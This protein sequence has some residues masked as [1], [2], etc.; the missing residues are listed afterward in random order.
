M[1]RKLLSTP[2]EK[3]V[4]SEV[5]EFVKAHMDDMEKNSQ[6]REEKKNRE[7]YL[8]DIANTAVRAAELIILQHI[9]DDFKDI[10]E[11][12]IATSSTIQNAIG[13]KVGQTIANPAWGPVILAGIASVAPIAFASF[14]ATQIGQY[15]PLV[16][17]DKATPLK[18]QKPE[19]G[20][21]AKL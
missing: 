17:K 18:I 21:I 20:V 7:V 10:I 1:A 8:E 3:S 6:D 5:K 2:A 4:I 19:G 14:S 16:V 13:L 11:H 12:A 9:K 15:T